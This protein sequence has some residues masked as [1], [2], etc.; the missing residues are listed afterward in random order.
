MAHPIIGCVQHVGEHS[1]C[2]PGMT[3]KVKS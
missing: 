1:T 3:W 2:K